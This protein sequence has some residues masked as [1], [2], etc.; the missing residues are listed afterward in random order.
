MKSDSATTRRQKT[1]VRELIRMGYHIDLPDWLVEGSTLAGLRAMRALMEEAHMRFQED[2][3]VP[4]ERTRPAEQQEPCATCRKVHKLEV[5]G[6]DGVKFWPGHEYI[7]RTVIGTQK[8]PRE[9]RMG[10]LGIG[11]GMEWS[12]RGPDRTHGGQYGGTQNIDLSQIVYAE[13]VP[14]DDALRHVCKVVRNERKSR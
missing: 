10:F 12:A 5:V 3:Q 4:A 9:W 13:E 7:I 2:D 14:R 8:Y 1:N 11:M 6:V